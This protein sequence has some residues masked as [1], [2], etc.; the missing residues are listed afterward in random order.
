[1]RIRIKTTTGNTLSRAARGHGFGSHV[2]YCTLN[3][4]RDKGMKETIEGLAKLR[5]GIPVELRIG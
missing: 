2:N 5:T 1:M 3:I 4:V